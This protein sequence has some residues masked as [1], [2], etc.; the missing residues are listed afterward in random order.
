MILLDLLLV[1]ILF[2]PYSMTRGISWIDET[3]VWQYNPVYS[4]E[5]M[6]LAFTPLFTLTMIYQTMADALLGKV[7]LL[8]S[9]I[10]GGMYSVNAL[11]ASP[12]LDAQDYIPHMGTY[13]LIFV[14]PVQLLILRKNGSFNV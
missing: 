14:F 8:F 13:I 3:E 6:L 2:S 12:F 1:A 5:F 7:S 11:F 4:D 9:L 10:I